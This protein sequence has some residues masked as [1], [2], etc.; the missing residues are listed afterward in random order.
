MKSIQ[1]TFIYLVVIL[2]FVSCQMQEANSTVIG[3]GSNENTRNYL[4]II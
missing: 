3:L 1:L 2:Q 4:E